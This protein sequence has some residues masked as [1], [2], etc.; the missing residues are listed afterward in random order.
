MGNIQVGCGGKIGG[1]VSALS[2]IMTS[3]GVWMMLEV[4]LRKRWALECGP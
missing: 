2:A 1:G 4:R 3:F